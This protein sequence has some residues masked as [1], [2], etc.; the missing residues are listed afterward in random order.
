M[1]RPDGLA[2]KK[3]LIALIVSSVQFTRQQ[4]NHFSR[5]PLLFWPQTIAYQATMYTSAMSIVGKQEQVHGSWDMKKQ[6][7]NIC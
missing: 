7:V 1:V 4:T 6:E 3:A 5:L 2:Y